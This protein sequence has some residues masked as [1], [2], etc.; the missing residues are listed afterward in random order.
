MVDLGNVLSHPREALDGVASVLSAGLA[1]GQDAVLDAAAAAATATAAAVTASHDGVAS[2]LLDT[3][4]APL[5]G[6]GH[7]HGIASRF[8]LALSA[9]DF[10]KGCIYLGIIF[11]ML[12]FSTCLSFIAAW[13]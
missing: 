11:A 2:D 13:T 7:A 5:T 6:H 8:G 3:L 12:A 4:M 1:N 10:R 9:G